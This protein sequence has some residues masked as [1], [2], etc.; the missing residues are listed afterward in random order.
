MVV[1]SQQVLGGPWEAPI[2]ASD[3]FQASKGLCLFFLSSLCTQMKG[4]GCLV[5]DWWVNLAVVPLPGW[6]IRKLQA[7]C[8]GNYWKAEKSDFC[9]LLLGKEYIMNITAFLQDSIVSRQV[10]P[11]VGPQIFSHIDW[12]ILTGVSLDWLSLN[13]VL[14]ARLH[15]MTMAA[16]RAFLTN[17]HMQLFTSSVSTVSTSDLL[18]Y[19]SPEDMFFDFFKF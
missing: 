2:L 16:V 11:Q 17:G 9:S 12:A 18:I 19:F 1:A 4:I 15:W 14:Y 13:Q 8:F 6:L 5:N 7:I 3:H 10:W